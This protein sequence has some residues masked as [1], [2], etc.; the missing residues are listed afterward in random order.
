MQKDKKYWFKPAKFWGYFAFYY[1]VSFSGWVATAVLLAIFVKLFLL[2]DAHS[3][4]GSDTLISFAPWAISIFL[5]FDMLCFHFGEYP[6][7]W[8]KK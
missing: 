1:P 5:L 8:G 7:W 2:A 4:S 6:S 3:H